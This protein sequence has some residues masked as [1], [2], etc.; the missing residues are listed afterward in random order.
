MSSPVKITAILTAR[1]G[2]ADALLILLKEMMPHCRAEHGN[3]GWDIWR[4][5]ESPDRYI[6]DALYADKIA[7]AEHRDTPHY[8]YY[9]SRVPDLAERVAYACNAVAVE[10]VPA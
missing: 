10:L 1:P 4:D 2:K 8:I 3:L 6:L 9:L 7:V 5:R